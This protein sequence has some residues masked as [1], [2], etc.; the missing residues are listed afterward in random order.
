MGTSA[1]PAIIKVSA[2]RTLVRVW[3]FLYPAFGCL[4]L[5]S[6]TLRFESPWFNPPLG[7]TYLTRDVATPLE[8]IVTRTVNRSPN[9]GLLPQLLW[10]ALW[11]GM[12]RTYR[13]N[14][15]AAD[16]RRDSL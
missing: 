16:L 5:T 6:T 12:L 15:G 1:Q 3:V 13:A 14:R 8:C 7:M 10:M 11:P 2:A 4:I 9:A